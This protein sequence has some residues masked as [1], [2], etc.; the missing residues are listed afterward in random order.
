MKIRFTIGKKIGFG[1]GILI[2]FTML[3]FYIT[4]N[5]LN[6]SREINDKIN[7]IYNPSVSTLEELKLKTIES[8]MLI[9]KWVAFPS[10]SDNPE[11]KKL[12]HIISE[13]YQHIRSK[14][15]QLSQY[16]KPDA[17]IQLDSTLMQ[18]DMLFS[19]YDEVK[20]LLPDFESYNDAENRF[21][22]NIAVDESS[23]IQ[24]LSNQILWN[25]ND[26]INNQKHQTAKVS[27]E[28]I[29][30]FDLL[31]FLIRYLGLA[32]VIGGVLVAFYTTRSI[33][34]PIH[35][36]KQILLELS[37]GKFPKSKLH[38]RKDEIGEMTHALN[39]LIEALESTRE[40]AD[41]LGKG[42]FNATYTPLSE[43][44]SMGYALLKM[45]DAL[46]ENERMLEQKV[47][48]R[49]AEVVRQKEEIEEQNIKISELYKEVTDSIRY[50][51]RIQEAILPPTEVINNYLPESFVLYRPKDIVSGDF[52]WF[53]RY[54]NKSYLAA[55]D[56]TG[57]GV[58]GAFMSIIGYNILNY[59]LSTTNGGSPGQLLDVLNKGVSNTLH[60][61]A[62]TE[63]KDGMD[64]AL[65]T[66]HHDTNM[67]EYAGAYNP[68]YIVRNNEVLKIKADKF[69]I[70][71]YH[72]NPN[73][74]YSNHKIEL[75]KGDSVYIF[76]DGY[77]DQ[78]GG[79]KG[80]KLMYNKFRQILL[81]IADLPAVEQ[82]KRLLDY[83]LEWKGS[84]E[85]VDDILIIGFKYI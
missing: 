76:S 43:Q 18:L 60:K 30:S 39:I 49:T 79:P 78:F 19:M 54:D 71:S 68:L 57:H 75:Q 28:M 4:N 3:V 45:R 26:L 56:C 46:A 9:Y 42:N 7:N 47:R 38:E 74:H 22:A 40:F 11:K 50:A 72:E 73:V 66:I 31:Q 16:W 59:A 61:T 17:K 6:N 29:K 13:E 53:E 58:P 2:V 81:Q 65:V 80:K 77:A 41:E 10:P 21:F 14:L 69:P 55:V 63:T 62:N 35:R 5:T 20:S 24:F 33:V 44:D 8:K 12:N 67:L 51:K 34:S 64:V 15:E 27:E 48:E 85:Q 70:G 83:L 32:L 25:L 36:L 52:Y 1:F 82:Q 37:V 23:E 84:L